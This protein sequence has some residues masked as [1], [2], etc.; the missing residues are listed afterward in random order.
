MPRHSG[1]PSCRQHNRFDLVA[2]PAPP[3]EA[4]AQFAAWLADRG[5]ARADLSDAE[6]KTDEVPWK[7]GAIRFRRYFVHRR[8]IQRGS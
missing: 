5:L 3:D 6:V 2:G 1:A 8:A 7:R 4:D